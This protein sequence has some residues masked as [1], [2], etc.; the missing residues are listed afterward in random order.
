MARLA[1]LSNRIADAVMTA[2]QTINAGSDANTW[3]TTPKTVR[4]GLL[5]NV[6]TLPNDPSLCVEV[7]NWRSV[8]KA[9][10]GPH[11]LNITINV[12]MKVSGLDL[13][14]QQLNSLAGDVA[15]ALAQAESFAG[16]PIVQT[17]EITYEPQTD[18]MLRNGLA[19]AT[20]AA[21]FEF[22]YD[23]GLTTPP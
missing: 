8:P 6:V 23:H 20:L 13:A 4:R 21:D 14:E 19:I 15:Y 17:G 3:L 2:L 12:H 10:G 18:L 11:R 5:A 16:L 9:G 22:E 1:A 7:G